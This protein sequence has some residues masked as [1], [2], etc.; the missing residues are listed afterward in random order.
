MGKW[1]TTGELLEWE[2]DKRQDK[3][4]ATRQITA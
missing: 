3:I 1:P 2:K 4:L